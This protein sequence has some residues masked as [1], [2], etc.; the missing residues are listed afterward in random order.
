MTYVP[1]GFTPNAIALGG[2]FV[3][4]SEPETCQALYARLIQEGVRTNGKRLY[5]IADV[6]EVLRSARPDCATY[7][8]SE[9]PLLCP[10]C[11]SAARPVFDPAL[12]VLEP[13]AEQAATE[14]QRPTRP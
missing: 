14:P 10:V 13:I 6:R 3:P 5:S 11:L 12:A 9:Q 1:F 7:L 8:E 2:Q 4:E